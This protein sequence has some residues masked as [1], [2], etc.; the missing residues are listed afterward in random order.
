MMIRIL[1]S[2][3]ESL[4]NILSELQEDTSVSADTIKDLHKA[5]AQITAVHNE[6]CRA[7]EL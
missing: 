1:D 6:L 7:E 4:D 3:A 5:V 2:V